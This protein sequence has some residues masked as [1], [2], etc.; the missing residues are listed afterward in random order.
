[1]QNPRAKQG[2]A[3]AVAGGAGLAISLWLPWY[4]VH[5]PQAAL[6]SVA[7]MSRQ[8]GALGGLIRSGAQLI[9]QLGPFHLTA[10]QVFKTVPA[11]LLV[12]AIIGG[13]LALLA[14]TDRAG[15]TSQL[16]RL[17]GG[18]G[19]VLVGYRI[20][21]P[22]G[23][24]GFVHPAWAIYLALLSSLAILAGG[25]LASRVGLDDPAVS[26]YSPTP[27]YTPSGPY[28]PAV[29]FAGSG[30]ASAPATITP[31]ADGGSPATSVPPPAA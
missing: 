19:A 2:H 27:A 15:D 4:T 12:I 28:A 1:M 22:P 14:L 5:I 8:F 20:A 26:G 10:W 18:V 16:T 17:A 6:N 7:A 23:Q 9:S 21:V 13:G 31:I 3:L 24:G 30:L 29:P 11:V 25:L